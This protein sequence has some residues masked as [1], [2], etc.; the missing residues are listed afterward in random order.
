MEESVDALSNNCCRK[1]VP[2]KLWLSPFP[3]RRWIYLFLIVERAVAV[4]VK[5]GKSSCMVQSQYRI[6]LNRASLI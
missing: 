4:A 5:F 1:A 6:F 2:H 3:L